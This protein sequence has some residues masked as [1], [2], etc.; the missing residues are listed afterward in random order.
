MYI[1]LN[2]VLLIYEKCA[3]QSCMT[4]ALVCCGIEADQRGMV[5]AKARVSLVSQEGGSHAVLFMV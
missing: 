2:L 4:L 1:V 3:N 5:S